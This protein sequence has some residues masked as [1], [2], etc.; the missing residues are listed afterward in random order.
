MLSS[1]AKCFINKNYVIAPILQQQIHEIQQ[2]IIARKPFASVLKS[3]YS[4][5]EQIEER[6]EDRDEREGGRK[7]LEK[8]QIIF[9]VGLG[10][11]GPFPN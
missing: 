1:E 10:L 6:K 4:S 2:I 11:L 8:S 9:L 5:H 7:V 3:H